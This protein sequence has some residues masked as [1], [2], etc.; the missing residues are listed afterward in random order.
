MFSAAPAAE[1]ERQSTVVIDNWGENCAT[2][3][4]CSHYLDCLALDTSHICVLARVAA[5]LEDQAT[6]GEVFGSLLDAHSCVL[7]RRLVTSVTMC[8]DEMNL[9]GADARPHIFAALPPN[10]LDDVEC[11]D[12]TERNPADWGGRVG[13]RD[14]TLVMVADRCAD[15]LAMMLTDDEQL[16]SD[17]MD[18]TTSGDNFDIG[19][20]PKWSFE[21][22]GQLQ[23]CGALPLDWLYSAATA[24][25]RHAKN[26]WHGALLQTKLARIQDTLNEAVYR[27]A[28]IEGD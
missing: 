3:R 2:D 4:S 20:L 22:L 6:V 15:E 14:R 26:T 19:V 21:F 16:Y 7:Q 23:A 11:I 27:S 18:L 12:D 28:D 5:E 13:G 9:A 10:A 24:E 1:P 8:R 17:A 25:E